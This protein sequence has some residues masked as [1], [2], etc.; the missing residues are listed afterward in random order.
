MKLVR[1][2]LDYEIDESKFEIGEYRTFRR[3]ILNSQIVSGKVIG[4]QSDFL[5]LRIYDGDEEENIF[6]YDIGTGITVELINMICDDCGHS[7]DG[8]PEEECPLCHSLNTDTEENAR[9]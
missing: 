9:N 3:G 8:R 7:F 1:E 6:A 2:V 4:I 5:T